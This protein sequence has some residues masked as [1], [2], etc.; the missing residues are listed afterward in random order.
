MQDD[1][2]EKTIQEN[3]GEI[4]ILIVDIPGKFYY[5][6]SILTQRSKTMDN[7]KDTIVDTYTNT[8]L[9]RYFQT[10]EEGHLPYVLRVMNAYYAAKSPRTGVYH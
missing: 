9:Q 4:T 2:V 1:L 8:P 5:T 10:V 6:V 3:P 7:T